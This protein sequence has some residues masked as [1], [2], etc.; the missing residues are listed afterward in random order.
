MHNSG[1]TPIKLTH[2]GIGRGGACEGGGFAV[3]N[4]GREISIQPNKTKKLE[5]SYVLFFRTG[6]VLLPGP[7]SSLSKCPV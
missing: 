5:L 4:C 7:F 2:I 6:I 1:P 3:A